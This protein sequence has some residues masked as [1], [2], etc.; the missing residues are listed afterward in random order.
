MSESGSSN[1]KDASAEQSPESSEPSEEARPEIREIAGLPLEMFVKEG[2]ST[3]ASDMAAKQ[4]F[5]EAEERRDLAARERQ[6]AQTEQSDQS[7]AGLYTNRMSENQ[8]VP[9][10]Y[11]ELLVCNHRGTQIDG[12]DGRPRTIVCE[13]IMGNDPQHA[14]ELVLMAVCPHCVL[15]LGVRQ[16]DAQIRIAQRHRS[17]HLDTRKE[18]Q[19]PIVANLFDDSAQDLVL[20]TLPRA[21]M[22]TDSDRI[23]CPRCS[24]VYRIDR[25]RLWPQ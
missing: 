11:V 15:D 20:K 14:D 10:G 8:D 22:V 19:K 7:V 25:N 5:A 3:W 2:T 13:I 4:R 12:P 17:W 16:D 21:G 23:P 18:H 24:W 9:A 1:V 6:V